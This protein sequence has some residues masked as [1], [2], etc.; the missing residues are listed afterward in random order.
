MQCDFTRG[1]GASF[2]TSSRD[3]DSV[4]YDLPIPEF[5]EPYLDIPQ[6]VE[7]PDEDGTE[8][9]LSDN[10][11]FYRKQRKH[12][13][14]PCKGK[15]DRY[16]RL[17]TRLVD[18]F[19]SNPESFDINNIELPPSF[20]R[21]ATLIRKLGNRIQSQL[22]QEGV[23][24]L[25][26]PGWQHSKATMPCTTGNDTRQN[27]WSYEGTVACHQPAH[28]NKTSRPWRA[29]SARSPQS[30]QPPA[31]M[32]DVNSEA[33]RSI[34]GS[35]S[36]N[37]MPSRWNYDMVNGVIPRNAT[38]ASIPVSGVIERGTAIPSRHMMPSFVG[39]RS[40]MQMQHQTNGRTI[41]Q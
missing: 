40:N 22:Q 3:S 29:Y 8:S 12:K 37:R 6:D 18:H 24:G 38:G 33:T 35:H 34:H 20:L 5:R 36:C 14:R 27:V 26:D 39:D 7:W 21:N 2:E 17:V 30:G 16:R 41:Y 15:R 1:R 32:P 10:Q 4:A 31:A 25:P 9:F 23:M 11:S 28:Q 13:L 19:R